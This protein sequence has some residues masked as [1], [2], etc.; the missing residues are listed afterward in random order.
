MAEGVLLL[1]PRPPAGGLGKT[2]TEALAFASMLAG[3]IG[4][5]LDCAVI[6][7]DVE[8]AAD[9][10]S[11]RGARRVFVASG[12]RFAGDGDALVAAAV[13]STRAADPAVVVIPR[14]A[15]VLALAPRLA[16]RLDGASVTGVTAAER[17][18]GGVIEALAA[19]FGGAARVRY[20][21]AADGPAV[22][23]LAPALAE[24]P[25]REAGRRVERL[26]LEVPATPE[27]VRVVEP[28]VDSGVDRLE[29]AR[30]VVSGG[31]GLQ[32]GEHFGL[33]RELAAALGGLP[34]ASR[35]IVDDAWA[36]AEEQVGLTGAIVTPDVYI[37]AGISGA[38]Q[39][40][41]GCSN[42]RIIVAINNDPNA[43]IF[44]YAHYGIVDD[45][46]EVLPAL[47]AARADA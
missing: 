27:R 41:A 24:A 44:R 19:V 6:G 23:G 20:R 9:E 47:I 1:V 10:A 4:G 45:C 31:R 21:F 36:P 25:P 39:H 40:M 37:A 33:I 34:G 17:G 42:A 30:V 16:A 29:D 8:G 13:E 43:P 22:L 7:E 12:G 3:N 28:A 5:E 46:L 11:E 2:A 38:S 26:E 18:E 14:G 35:A 32:S 15:D